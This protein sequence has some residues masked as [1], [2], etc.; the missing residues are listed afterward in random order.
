MVLGESAADGG[1]SARLVFNSDRELALNRAEH[2]SRHWDRA[3]CE[4][5]PEWNEE[6][7]KL[8]KLS[9]TI[10]MWT[11]TFGWTE[12][13]QRAT[14]PAG[15]LEDVRLAFD[16]FEIGQGKAFALGD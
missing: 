15:T 1:E 2:T 14:A 11:E 8:T 9:A 3:W 16:E 5:I 4:A 7:P 13:Q 6:E 12:P 10:E